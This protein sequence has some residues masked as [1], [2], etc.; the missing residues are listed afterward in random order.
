MRQKNS[1]SFQVY[2]I[3]SSIVIASSICYLILPRLVLSLSN[4]TISVPIEKL[5]RDN[6]YGKNYIEYTYKN[7]FNQNSY[8]VRKQLD[9]D[10]FVIL[11]N[12]KYIDIQYS[13]YYPSYTIIKLLGDS[14]YKIGLFFICLFFFVFVFYKNKL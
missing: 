13:K 1:L 7:E 11:E 12:K 10:E 8:K 2:F 3:L 14:N 5:Y 6:E 9:Y 4:N